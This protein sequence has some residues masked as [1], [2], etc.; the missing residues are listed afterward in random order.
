[1]GEMAEGLVGSCEAHDW[2]RRGLPE[3]T[4][5][6]TT[7]RRVLVGAPAEMLTILRL[8]KRAYERAIVAIEGVVSIECGTVGSRHEGSDE[9][10]EQ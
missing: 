9:Q 6:C 10:G 3:D 7:C 8:K 4:Y 2:K 5:D 1:M